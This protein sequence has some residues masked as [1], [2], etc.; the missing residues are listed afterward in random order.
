MMLSLFR[1]R[2]NRPLLPSIPSGRRVYA[3]GDV[4]GRLDLLIELIDRIRRDHHDRPSASAA[5]VMLGD[6]IDR[7]PQSAEVIAFLM[8]ERP[9]FATFRFLM[10]NHEEAML[11]SLQPRVDL[12]ETG[13]LN[14]G[15]LE[16]LASY[17]VPLSILATSG[18]LLSDGLRRYIPASHI[19][20]LESFEDW[21][22]EGDYLFVHAGIRPGV[23]LDRQKPADLRWIR[24]EFLNDRRQHEHIVVHGH[25]I[26][27][28]PQIRDNR[29]GI[30]TGAYHSGVLTALA[31]EGSD[32]WLL[33]T[34]P[35]QTDAGAK[36]FVG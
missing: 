4:H 25:T 14:F 1:N 7:G 29:I 3:I 27:D 31:L 2:A 9:D 32:R 6:L 36:H 28:Q 13:W 35:R 16:T 24:G 20:F 23:P 17:G 22:V 8:E 5:I 33:A 34:E 15:G 11:D 12:R 26:A 18:K 21:V 10:G 30:D 19:A